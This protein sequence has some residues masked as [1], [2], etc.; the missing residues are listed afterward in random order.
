MEP[1]FQTNPGWSSDW[2]QLRAVVALLVLSTVK[3]AATNYHVAPAPSGSDA[4]DCLS[5]LKACATFQRAVDL[6]PTGAHC[7]IVPAPGIYSQK[8]N[9]FYYKVISVSGPRDK[10]DNCIDRG[11]VVVDDRINGVGQAGS[12]FFVQDHAILTI[13]CMTLAAYANGSVGFASRQF[14]IG[15][16][17]YV[18]FGQFRGGY[19]VAASETSKVNIHSPGIYGDA[20]QF[21][22]AGDLSQVTI[23]GTIKIGDGLTFDVAF[24]SAASNSVVSV[25]PLTIVGG[26]GMSGASYQ[27]RDAIIKKNAI[28]PGGDVSYGE[29]ENCTVLGLAPDKI[30]FDD[31]L[32]PIYSELDKLNVEL[33]ANR[34][35]HDKLDVELKAI[36][37]E[38]NVIITVLVVLTITAMAGAF[39]VWQQHWRR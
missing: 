34:I 30:S 35:D 24:L 38:R 37:T 14:A 17:N 6:C 22:S 25:Y 23:G 31:K 18:D 8:T 21:A 11:A 36:R 2:K 20:S 3:A 5:P 9:V 19:G 27:C 7:S 33:K 29:K 12:I 1:E 13:S 32:N 28:L 39:H 26:A 16:V 4:N 10:N 15:D